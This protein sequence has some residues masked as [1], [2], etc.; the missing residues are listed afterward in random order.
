M[1]PGASW[2]GY[3]LQF[4]GG[5]WSPDLPAGAGDSVKDRSFP[6][7]CCSQQAEP[8]PQHRSAGRNCFPTK[9]CWFLHFPSF[10]GLTVVE[11]GMSCPDVTPWEGDIPIVDTVFA[12]I[13]GERFGEAGEQAGRDQ[14][15]QTW[16][17]RSSA[18]S[19]RGTPALSLARGWPW[20]QSGGRAAPLLPGT[21]CGALPRWGDGGD[22]GWILGTPGRAE[23][24]EQHPEVTPAPSESQLSRHPGDVSRRTGISRAQRPMG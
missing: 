6:L 18:F 8:P 13:P 16:R 5:F 17:D 24:P 23:R 10:L 22:R 19:R 9:Q 1:Q 20:G 3:M 12:S 11:T 7:G 4:P 14:A 2:G 15:L 21:K